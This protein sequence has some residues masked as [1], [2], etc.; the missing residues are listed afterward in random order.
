MH[1]SFERER[2][3]SRQLAHELRTP[4]AEIRT[5]IDVALR[6]PESQDVLVETLREVEGVGSQMER[7]LANLLALA[8]ADAGIE[9]L[10]ADELCLGEE[11]DRVAGDLSA[12]LG[13]RSISVRN[14]IAGEASVVM[15][16]PVLSLILRN[17]V[18]NA[19]VHAD[20]STWVEVSFDPDGGRLSF[21][22]PA[23][24][25]VAEDLP[26]LFE[27]FWRK[28]ADRLLGDRVGLGLTLVRELARDIGGDATAQLQGGVLSITIEGLR[29]SPA[30]A[31][32]AGA[33]IE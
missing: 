25:L 24:D 11:L 20:P 7:L 6:W 12:R 16:E 30:P 14:R 31:G 9:G 27:R 2:E 29:V 5:A 15:P 33:P 13:E 8:R 1:E 4:L 23:S 32:T 28:R 10:R 26:N 18:A 21:R 17:L 22:N 3:F 19:A